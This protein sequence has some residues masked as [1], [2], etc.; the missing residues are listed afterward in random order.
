[1]SSPSPKL[2]AT[3]QG[4]PL[5]ELPDDLYIPA[6]YFEI[7]LEQFEG[8]LDLLLYLIR[9]KNF[10]ILNLPVGPITEQYLHYLEKFKKTRRELALEYLVMAATLIELKSRLLLPPIKKE[11]SDEEEIDPRAALIAR[12][13]AYEQCQKLSHHIDELPRI[14]RDFF[15]FNRSLEKQPITYICSKEQLYQALQDVLL[16]QERLEPHALQRESFTVEQAC[17]IVM[18]HLENGGISW[19][20][21]LRTLPAH[22]RDKQYQ[23]TF[24]LAILE[25]SKQYMTIIF[26]ESCFGPILI[27]KSKETPYE[28]Q[29]L[30]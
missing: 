14:D 25:L 22:M 7:L 29:L 10:D 23:I 6:D 27:M 9:K 19:H 3:V 4:A 1:M 30:S 2:L 17:E 12:L 18:T 28:H 15:T 11:G 13:Q 16:K 24:F 20:D 21:W 5:T 26:Q 8:P